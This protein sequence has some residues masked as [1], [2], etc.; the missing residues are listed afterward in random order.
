[1]VL[2]IACTWSKTNNWSLTRYKLCFAPHAGIY[3]CYCLYLHSNEVNRVVAIVCSSYSM[4]TVRSR[5]R[6]LRCSHSERRQQGRFIGHHWSWNEVFPAINW[7]IMKKRTKR[8]A[9]R[10][11]LRINMAQHIFVF[12]YWTSMQSY[13]YCYIISCL[14]NI[15]GSTKQVYKQHYKMY[16][17]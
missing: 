14:L 13:F 4:S 3:L 17:Q 15:T 6:C 5:R 1:M 7:P 11:T 8:E 12:V 16:M 10:R 2:I 9:E